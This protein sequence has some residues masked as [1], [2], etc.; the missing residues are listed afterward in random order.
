FELA[1]AL[2]KEAQGVSKDPNSPKAAAL[3]KEAQKEFASLAAAD[4]DYT[5]KA[6]QLNLALSFQKMGA[7]TPVA[8]L[9]DFDQCYLKARYDVPKM[10][11]TASAI[12]K[13]DADARE[14]LEKERTQHLR[15]AIAAF[16]RGLQLADGKTSFSKLAD[17]RY[18]LAYAYLMAGDPYRAPIVGEDL[19]PARPP[20]KRS[21]AA[22][23][24]APGADG[25]PAAHAQRPGAPHPPPPP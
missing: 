21:A 17:A 15:T 24:H 16:R 13:A 25:P 5:E 23:G 9:K 8:D 10:Q 20:T 14:K 3:Y 19:A 2:L 11:D 22:A 6:A 18:Y 7:K 4:S 1:N 12:A